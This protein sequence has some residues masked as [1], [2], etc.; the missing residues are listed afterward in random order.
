M[1]RK[2]KNK[3]STSKLITEEMEFDIPVSVDNGSALHIELD[4]QYRQKCPD[5]TRSVSPSLDPVHDSDLDTPV[6][7]QQKRSR[8]DISLTELQDNVIAALTSKIKESADDLG[9]MITSNTVSIEALKKSIDFVFEEVNALK[10]D[11]KSCKSTT[12]LN[13]TKIHELEQRLNDAERYQRRWN[14]RLYGIPEHPE[15][16]ITHKVIGICLSV[17]PD[18]SVSFKN[19]ID[20]V[21]RLGKLKEQ[22]GR[23]R[24]VIIR[25]VR[26]STRDLIWRLA[27]TS[28]YLR[29]HKLRFT[30]DLSQA[31]KLLR[32]K[33]WPLI[34]AARKE[35]KKAFFVGV[36]VIIDGKEVRS[37]S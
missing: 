9:K 36:R 33:R 12:N 10:T 11:M 2:G 29:N 21:H 27:K 28:E 18:S 15:E 17:A 7:P 5:I 6:K 14:L 24:P 19:D 34:E 3:N 32:I 26:R 35:G 30:E 23:P 13:S 1:K 22:D 37:P 20:V 31:D 8:D 4:H 16:D 25:F